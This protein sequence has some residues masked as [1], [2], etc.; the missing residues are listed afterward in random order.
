MAQP[1]YIYNP[2]RCRYEP[3]KITLAQ[4]LTYCCALLL[5]GG[6]LFTGISFLQ[7]K[8]FTPQSTL[9]LRAEN[10]ALQKHHALL[11]RELTD[12]NATLT[13]LKSTEQVIESKL[14][15]K[16]HTGTGNRPTLLQKTPNGFDDAREVLNRIKKTVASSSHKSVLSGYTYASTL[17][18]TREDKTA[19]MTWP[20]AQPVEHQYLK[21]ASGFGV[22]IHP[23]H[24]GN[25]HHP[26]LDLAAPK[27]TPVMATGSGTVIDIGRSDLQVGY[28]N[29]IEI[30]H[31]NGLVTRYAHLQDILVKPGQAV[32]KRSPIGTI[33]SSG[34][35]TAPHLH[36]EVLRHGTQ[37]DPLQFMIEGITSTE[38]AQLMQQGKKKNQSLD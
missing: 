5:A 37:L 12:V 1:H 26:G 13:E 10:A 35:A 7:S 36:Y 28:G 34:G 23:F 6:V 16:T 33:G 21:I 4:I 27:G 32:K 24:K 14:F 31:G 38:F 30:D 19:I 17:R 25:Y 2:T 20:S 22:R 29:Y 11:T 18:L 8:F 3:A 15:G 9:A